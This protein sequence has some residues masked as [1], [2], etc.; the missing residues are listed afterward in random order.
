LTRATVRYYLHNLD[1]L[2]Q[3]ISDIN[4]DL[5]DYRAMVT[6]EFIVSRVDIDA[7]PYRSGGNYKQLWPEARGGGT[8]YNN[9]SH[10]EQ[11]AVNR[12]DFI[13]KLEQELFDKKTALA[14]INCVLYYLN[15]YDKQVDKQ[16][17]QLRYKEH[18]T[19]YQVHKKTA[20]EITTLKHKDCQI[21]DE[22]ISNYNARLK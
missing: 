11:L 10:T 9:S 13:T 3:E 1:G 6:D 19:W 15:G 20:Y 22:I 21:V 14:A 16:I 7:D 8:H 5:G 4:A 2:Q 18:K 17:I 12:A